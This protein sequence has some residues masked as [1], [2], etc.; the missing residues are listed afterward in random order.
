LYEYLYK[1]VLQDNVFSFLYRICQYFID[2]SVRKVYDNIMENHPSITYLIQ[3]GMREDQAVTYTTLL[4]K[5]KITASKLAGFLSYSR[6][7][8]YRLLDELIALNLVEKTDAP[9]MVSTFE[10]SHPTKLREWMMREREALAQRQKAVEST[11]TDLISTYTALSG[12]PGVRVLQGTAGIEELYEDILNER[13]PICLIRSPYD[14]RHPEIFEKVLTQITEQVRLGITT[15]AITPL[16][17]ETI[18]ELEILDRKNLVT[19]RLLELEHLDIPA[20]IILYADK[21]AITAFDGE[22]MTTIIQNKAISGTFQ[23]VFEFIWRALEQE[24][25]RIRTG[26]RD[27][28]IAAPRPR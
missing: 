9:K 8:V 3:A 19:R 15:R 10:C 20:Q 22:L 2:N 28:T 6:P 26:L 25:A 14:D 5:G 21:V 23:L 24:D 7:N 1:I 12:K 27:G 18:E 13:A 16:D 11:L 17:N 4:T